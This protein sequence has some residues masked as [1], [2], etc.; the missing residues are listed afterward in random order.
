[1]AISN[2]TNGVYVERLAFIEGLSREF[3]ALTGRGVYVFFNPLDLDVLFDK[4]LSLGMSIRA[5][6]RQCV[7]N[8][9]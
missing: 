3:L 9:T 6:A 8:L 7:R 5:F 2:Q 1:M 4:Y